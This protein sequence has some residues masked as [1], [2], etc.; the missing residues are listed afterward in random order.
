M[1]ITTR[2]ILHYIFKDLQLVIH[3][4]NNNH[5]K[6]LEKVLNGKSKY[7]NSDSKYSF[8]SIINVTAVKK[9]L[10]LYCELQRSRIQTVCQREYEVG[11]EDLQKA[12][13]LNG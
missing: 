11:N 9:D 3:Y 10:N 12:N 7:I 2:F 8:K 4:N 13:K 1:A 6:W 5:Q